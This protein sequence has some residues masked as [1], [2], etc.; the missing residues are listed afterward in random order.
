MKRTA[1]AGLFL[2]TA[3]L[4]AAPA[5]AAEDL[6]ASNLQKIDNELATV[7]PSNPA[8]EKVL[9][10]SIEK[11]KSDQAAGKTKDCIAESQKVLTQLDKTT[12]KGSGAGN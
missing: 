3:L 11:A 2:S 6:C 9:K 4:G 5:F 12:K 1:L 10:P 8:L 7:A